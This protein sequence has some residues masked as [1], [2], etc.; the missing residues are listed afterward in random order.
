MANYYNINVTDNSNEA[1]NQITKE[2]SDNKSVLNISL[3]HTDEQT[4][5]R[6]DSP[7]FREELDD[8]EP[9]SPNMNGTPHRSSHNIT[10]S[11]ESDLSLSLIDHEIET[12][13]NST[14]I[15][16]LPVFDLRLISPHGRTPSPI[17][18]SDDDND[19]PASAR[20]A[21]LNERTVCHLKNVCLN[22]PDY[23]AL[24]DIN[25]QISPPI[26]HINIQNQD[27]CS[28]S[29]QEQGYSA[30]SANELN[31]SNSSILETIFE[32]VFLNTPP[33]N[34]LT[35]N[36]SSNRR[37]NLERK[38]QEGNVS[39]F[40]SF[41]KQRRNLR[42]EK[43][44]LNRG[45]QNIVGKENFSPVHY[46]NEEKSSLVSTSITSSTVSSRTLVLQ[47]ETIIK[48]SVTFSSLKQL[49]KS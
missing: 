10:L 11:S 18:I 47:S 43:I 34:G 29:N 2:K 48:N 19:G 27:F 46:S 35:I 16:E 44:V 40:I 30:F 9:K 41:Q 31:H 32:G 39:G 21:A 7:S 17:T 20:K 37:T 13:M 22:N 49:P 42:F 36:N 26:E 1:N 45:E 14:D 8:Y 5:L 24:K 15:D 33:R 12:Y 4:N 3:N 28:N 38:A 6:P 25:A 23:I